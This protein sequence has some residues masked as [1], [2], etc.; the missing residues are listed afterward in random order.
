MNTNYTKKVKHWITGAIGVMLIASISPVSAQVYKDVTRLGTNQAICTPGIESGGELQAFFANNPQALQNILTSAGWSGNPQDLMDAV[1]AGDFSKKM[2]APGTEFEWMSARQ[3]GSEVALPYRRWAGSEAFDGFEVNVVS[4]CQQHQ[5]V[6]PNACCNVSLI[7]S[8]PVAVG[9]P[10]L[11]T[12]ISGDT[13]TVCSDEGAALKLAYP[14][15]QTQTLALD[16]NSCWSGDLPPGSYSLEAEAPG[17]CGA[18]VARA[19]A[20]I[21]AAAAKSVLI[22]YIGAFYGT[23]TRLRFEQDFNMNMRDTSGVTAIK[24]GILSPINK[25]LSLFVQGGYISRDGINQGNIYPENNLF[26][27]IGLEK[28]VGGS[29]FIGGGIGVWNIDDGDFDDGSIFI[30]A[31][32]NIGNTPL[33]WFVEGRSFIDDIEDNKID[34]MVS[35]G[36]RYLFK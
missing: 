31:G 8:S 18:G 27:D 20:T 34:D 26:L 19:S 7:G 2:Y 24:A 14:S 5:I 4:N 28:S 35:A 11:T 6:I 25:T 3:S 32:S 16:G 33:Q 9:Q 17:Q 22:P 36:I 15:G 23:E 30:H 12:S 1:A 13:L 21:V 29:G 10:N